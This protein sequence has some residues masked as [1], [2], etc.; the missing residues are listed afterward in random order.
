MTSV[1]VTSS[2]INYSTTPSEGGA[3]SRCDQDTE[4]LTNKVCAGV[5]TAVDLVLHTWHILHRS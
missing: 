3:V 2:G 1:N 4:V 5:Y